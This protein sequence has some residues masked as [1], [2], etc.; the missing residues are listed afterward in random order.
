[1]AK[2]K[3]KKK[4]DDGSIE[5][6]TIKYAGIEITLPQEVVQVAGCGKDEL[7]FVDVMHAFHALVDYNLVRARIGAEQF[8]LPGEGEAAAE[9]PEGGEE[10]ESS[11]AEEGSNV[12]A[13]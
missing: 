8:N 12:A 7:T 13:E 6:Q 2:D 9:E 5:L 4:A 1:M 11:A 10:E 3:A